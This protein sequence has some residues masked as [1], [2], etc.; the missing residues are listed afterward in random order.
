MVADDEVGPMF[1]A[2]NLN[3]FKIALV[4]FMETRLRVSFG[5]IVLISEF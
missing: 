3:V 2:K 4:S 5:D 1:L